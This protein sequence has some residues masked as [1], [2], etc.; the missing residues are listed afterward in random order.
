MMR[1]NLHGGDQCS[2]IRPTPVLFCACACSS[3][4]VNVITVA[5]YSVAHSRLPARVAQAGV[6]TVHSINN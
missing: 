3:R 1:I 6:M 5:A 2:G 4:E